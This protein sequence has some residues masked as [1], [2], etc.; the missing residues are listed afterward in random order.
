MSHAR[1]LTPPSHSGPAA[2]YRYSPGLATPSLIF[3][4]GQVGR[5]DAGVVIEDPREQFVTAFEHV[6]A[7]LALAGAGF[8]HVVELTTFHTSFEEFEVF[9]EVKSGYFTSEP[10]PAW[11]A[12]GVTALALPKLLVEVKCI[13]D[14]TI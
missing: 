14:P 3:V 9:A 13:A 4:S 1:A 7:V 5:S 2:R 11:T 6:G 8:R 10:F 12:V